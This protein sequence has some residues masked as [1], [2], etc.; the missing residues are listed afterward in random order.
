[1]TL[2]EL[3]K[4]LRVAANELGD[5]NEV[6]LGHNNIYVHTD[7]V[8]PES[9]YMREHGWLIDGKAWTFIDKDRLRG[10]RRL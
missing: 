3:R 8:P 2:G 1:M 6:V 4:K 5:D 9:Q 7:D 10:G